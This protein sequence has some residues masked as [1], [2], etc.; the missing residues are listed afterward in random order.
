MILKNLIVA[1]SYYTVIKT[2]SSTKALTTAFTLYGQK[3]KN[4]RRKDIY[5]FLVTQLFCDF[6]WT[7]GL[8]NSK[9]QR[10]WFFPGELLSAKVTVAGSGLVNW[11]LQTQLSVKE[12][13]NITLLYWEKKIDC[14]QLWKNYTYFTITPGLRS[15]LFC[16]ICSSSSSS[17]FDVP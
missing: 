1:H 2:N 7:L 8:S 16:T 17:L 10:L 9:H 3:I 12:T 11:P 15:K 14:L 13:A 6:N 4:W 5:V